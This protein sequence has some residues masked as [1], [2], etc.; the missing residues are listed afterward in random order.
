MALREPPFRQPPRTDKPE[1]CFNRAC[2]YRPD[3]AKL[4][5]VHWHCDTKACRWTLCH[6][7]NKIANDLGRTMEPR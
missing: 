7:C 6:K 3:L 1:V 5:G 2:R 4:G